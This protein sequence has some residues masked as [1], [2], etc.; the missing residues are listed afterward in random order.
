MNELAKIAAMNDLATV[1][2][3]TWGDTGHRTRTS[4]QHVL[5]GEDG[6]ITLCGIPLPTKDGSDFDPDEYDG[7][8][9]RCAR[10]AR[11]DDRRSK[12]ARL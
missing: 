2:W 5:Y 1:A 9:Q 10:M 11:N 6:L 3:T 7:V 8:C 12:G 4:K